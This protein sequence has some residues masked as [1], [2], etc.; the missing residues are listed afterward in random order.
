VA[1]THR[2][3]AVSHGTRPHYPHKRHHSLVGLRLHGV[4]DGRPAIAMV[5]S[6]AL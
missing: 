4:N 2:E 6:T 3:Q 5:F 1:E